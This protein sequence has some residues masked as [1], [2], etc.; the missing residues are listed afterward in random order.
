MAARLIQEKSMPVPRM[1]R[2][3]IL[4]FAEGKK[5]K[6]LREANEEG[7][8]SPD[9]L[10]AMDVQYRAPTGKEMWDTQAPFM[11]RSGYDAMVERTKDYVYPERPRAPA[12]TAFQTLT[13][14]RSIKP[15]T[16]AAGFP[17]TAAPAIPTS[18][19]APV[20]PQST[21]T[22][23]T[24]APAPGAPAPGAITQAAPPAA[25]RPAAPVSAGI[26]TPGYVDAAA[27]PEDPM[28]ATLK[29][30]LNVPAKTQKEI[31][32][33]QQK[34]REAIGLGPN[35]DL[36]DYRSKIMAERANLDD[37]AKRQK[38]LRLA[39]FFA[40]WGSTPGATL[41][42]GMT[43]FR[44]TVPTLIEDEKERKKVLRETDKL[45]YDLGQT[46]RLEK[47]GNWDA[48]GEEK[49]KLAERGMK[50]NEIALRYAGQREQNLTQVAT[51]NAQGRGQ[52]DTSVY[53]TQ[54]H[55]K[56]SE[57]TAAA[58][59]EIAAAQR[60]STNFARI[61]GALSTAYNAVEIT[62]KN[63]ENIRNGKDYQ[64]SKLKLDQAQL[65]LQ[66]D[67]NNQSKIKAVEE[68]RSELN[69]FETDALSRV[70]QAQE[71]Y[72]TAKAMYTKSTGMPVGGTNKSSD[73]DPL[74]ILK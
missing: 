6:E 51:S 63:V 48:A 67:P 50:I 15:T 4:A 61:Q 18:P 11:D 38:N 29:R 46:E 1:A 70:K 27:P 30:E 34:D 54:M 14:E 64:T 10:T 17:M 22:A 74:G 73:K 40:T 26:K 16:G 44:K 19:A 72:D 52:M 2:G 71:M 35:Q 47:K 25:P 57:A 20:T 24:G 23:P 62:Q 13:S 37:D 33:Q 43:A 59:R 68:A 8:A 7:L 39:E 5:V 32:D 45:I 69:R 49:N 12:P 65:M 31:Y 41:V 42:A 60:E 21:P 58:S 66:N 28:I 53:N 3:G 56:A 55:L 36:I 9:E